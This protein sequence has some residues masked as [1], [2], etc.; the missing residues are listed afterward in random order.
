[1]EKGWQR[2]L[3]TQP[4]LALSEE[5]LDVPWLVLQ[6]EV[7][8]FQ[9]CFIMVQ[10]KLRGCQVVQTFHFHIQQLSFLVWAEINCK[11]PRARLQREESPDGPR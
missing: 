6:D 1:M 2:L 9:G 10:F 7:T 11:E 3:H 8:G 4:H 5:R